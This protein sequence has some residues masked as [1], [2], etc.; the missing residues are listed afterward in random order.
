M[1]RASSWRTRTLGDLLSDGRS[2][3]KADS[4]PART[5]CQATR[6]AY[7]CYALR[8]TRSVE[9]LPPRF[10]QEEDAPLTMGGVAVFGLRSFRQTPPSLKQAQPQR[11]QA[12][13]ATDSHSDQRSIASR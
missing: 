9:R 1:P 5:R 3:D 7:S 2:L 6:R 12:S 8:L 13:M 11:S 4:A 10:P